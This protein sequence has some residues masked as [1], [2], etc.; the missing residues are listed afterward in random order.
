MICPRG[1]VTYV[2]C[3]MAVTRCLVTLGLLKQNQ[4]CHQFFLLVNG[5]DELTF[6]RT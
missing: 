3:P 4:P 1:R 5:V 2:S 6:G